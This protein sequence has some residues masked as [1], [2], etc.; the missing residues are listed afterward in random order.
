VKDAA[1]PQTHRRKSKFQLGLIPLAMIATVAVLLPLYLATA[2][3]D[4]T[5]WDSSEFMTAAHTLGIP[6]PPG[7]PLWTAAAHVFSVLFASNGPA[8]S[9]TML[10]VLSTVAACALGARLIARWLPG[11]GGVAAAVCAAVTAGTMTSVWANATETEVYAVSLLLAAAMITAGDFAGQRGVTDDQRMRGRALV[12]FFVGLTVPVHLSA[13]VAFPAAV[14]FAWC[15]P[16]VRAKEILVWIAVALL[17]F[18]A[19]AILPLRA[20]MSPALNSGNPIDFASLYALLTRAQYDVA[21][22]WPRRAPLWIQTGNLFEWA[23][24]QV[25]LGLEPRVGPSWARTPFTVLWGWFGVLGLRH[26]WQVNRR[27]GRGMAML[28]VSASVG[29]VVWLNMLA[30]PSFGEGVLP[31]LAQHEARERDYFFALAFWAWGLL[32][33]AGIAWTAARLTH[34]MPRL[35]GNGIRAAALMLAAVPLIANEPAMNR[36]HLPEALL[37]RNFARLLLDAVPI[38][39]V[40]MVAGDNDTFPLWYLQNVE[41][42]REDVSIVSVPL[43]GAQWYRESLVKHDRILPAT[44]AA[45]WVGMPAM[46]ASIGDSALARHRALRVSAFLSAAE[47]KMV[48][49]AHGWLL[50]GL[51]YAPTEALAAGVTGLDLGVLARASRAVPPSFLTPISGGVDNTSETM[52][53]LLRCT[54]VTSLDDPLLARV[55]NGG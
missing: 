27:V 7:T 44:F 26:M 35:L 31:A 38:G 20:R 14:V 23:D 18:S 28:V 4:L 54:G 10:S 30:G 6:H 47:R 25:A 16:R 2:A 41:H 39:G 52:Q 13:M 9:V 36:T 32:A 45:Q 1:T 55:C 17:G 46:L 29:V 5:F 40:L 12:A 43:L 24:W 49:P 34:K 50:E 8:R 11:R 21:G 15:G 22:L 3:P 51:V 19:V 53:M 37:P 42:F 33:G 48:Q